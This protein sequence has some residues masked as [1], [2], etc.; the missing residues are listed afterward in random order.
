MKLQLFGGPVI[1]WLKEQLNFNKDQ[2]EDLL[3]KVRETAGPLALGTTQFI[4]SF[5]LDFIVGLTV[6]IVGLYYFLADGPEMI[7]ALMRLSPLDDRY[8]AQLLAQF[9]EL[10]RAVIL[11]M[12][13][14]AVVQGLLAGIGYLVAGFGNVFILTLVTM[15]FAMVPF[16]G[17]TAVWGGCCLWLA[18]HDGRPQAAIALAVYGVVVVSLA[19]NLIKPMVLHGRSNLHPL[20]ALLSVLGGAKALGPIG[21]VLGPIVVAFLQTLLVMLRSELMAMDASKTGGQGN[22]AVTSIGLAPGAVEPATLSA[23]APAGSEKA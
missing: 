3:V 1:A 12:L 5:L 16:I 8:E 15:V 7:T 19:D 4:S 20:L 14:A 18:L 9:S 21:I 23:T 10:T 2:V 17:A 13:L 6:M 22:A 11:A